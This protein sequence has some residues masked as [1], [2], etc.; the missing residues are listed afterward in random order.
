MG[1]K[2]GDN[3]GRQPSS[4]I[5]VA[6]DRKDTEKLQIAQKV[7]YLTTNEFCLGDSLPVLS[8][9]IRSGLEFL[10]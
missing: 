8:C 5:K 2:G 3:E 6:N 1:I 7:L 10:I 9:S 4:A